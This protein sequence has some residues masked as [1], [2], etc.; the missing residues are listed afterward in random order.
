MAENE[1]QAPQNEVKGADEELGM[2]VDGSSDGCGSV[3]GESGPCIEDT[4]NPS[5]P[6]EAQAELSY[7]KNA[8][9]N[10]K[11]E[12]DDANSSYLKVLADSENYRKRMLREKEEALKFSNEKIIKELLTVIDFIE[13]AI[14][15]SAQYIE[16]DAS[17]N[18]KSFVD[19]VRMAHGEFIKVLKNN[20]V[21]IIETEGKNFDPNFHEAVEMVE[22]SGKPGG[23]ILDEKRRGYSFK[24]RLL[25]PSMVSI[26]KF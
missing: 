10:L 5:N 23:T 13:L 1:K 14:G 17:G 11:K 7:L 25:R 4:P 9:K 15:H 20:G 22:N 24:E 18:L 19:G 3:A 2:K 21:E 8:V 26:A 6:D 16:S 12:L